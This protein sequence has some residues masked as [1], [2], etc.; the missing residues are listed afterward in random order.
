MWSICSEEKLHKEEYSVHAARFLSCYPLLPP[1]THRFLVVLSLWHMWFRPVGSTIRE[2]HNNRQKILSVLADESSLNMDRNEQNRWKI[3]W[4][5][6]SG[7]PS[8]FN[9]LSK[10]M[11]C[12]PLWFSPSALSV[13]YFILSPLNTPRATYFLSFLG[14]LL[15]NTL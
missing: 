10:H 12:F 7:F 8:M 9:Y 1:L 2:E 4:P 5:L 13:I 11:H 6:D 3:C 15:S 14:H